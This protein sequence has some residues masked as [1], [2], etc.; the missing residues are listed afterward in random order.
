M[1]EARRVEL[2]FRD[3]KS[4]VLPIDDAS[5]F[6]H[7]NYFYGVNCDICVLQFGFE[8]T[9]VIEIIRGGLPTLTP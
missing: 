5:Y 8:I 9:E 6:P 1:V 4:L 7:F 3:R 2:R